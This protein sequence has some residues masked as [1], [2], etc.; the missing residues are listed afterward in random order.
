MAVVVVVVVVAAAAVVVLV[1]VLVLVAWLPFWRGAIIF[2][3]LFLMYHNSQHHNQQRVLGSGG[4][5][6]LRR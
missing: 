2:L 4:L 5:G 1:L 6:I 3:F